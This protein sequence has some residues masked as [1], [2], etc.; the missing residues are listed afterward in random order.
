MRGGV[1]LSILLG[2]CLAGLAVAL[3]MRLMDFDPTT[4]PRALRVAIVIGAEFLGALCF[5][6]GLLIGEHLHWTHRRFEGRVEVWIT[7]A[8]ALLGAGIVAAWREYRRTPNPGDA[9][10]DPIA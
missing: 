9:K 1:A 3:Y 8:A 6:A 7:I 10:R 2:S 4:Q 5:V